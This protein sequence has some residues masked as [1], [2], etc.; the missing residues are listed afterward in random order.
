VLSALDRVSPEL[1]MRHIMFRGGADEM[2]VLAPETSHARWIAVI[3]PGHR[4]VDVT[5]WQGKDASVTM[6][7]DRDG[8]AVF[9]DIAPGPVR[10]VYTRPD[11][12]SAPSAH[13]AHSPHSANGRIEVQT[14]WVLIS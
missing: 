6:R 12:D 13:S 3:V 4:E 7:C 10:F 11:C 14:E 8:V 5:V 2:Y 1:A 9:P